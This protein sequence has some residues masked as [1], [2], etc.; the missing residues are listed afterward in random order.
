M[1][2]LF[3]GL[4]VYSQG[5]NIQ[6]LIA[7]EPFIR[8][9]QE[10][11]QQEDFAAVE[12][13]LFDRQDIAEAKKM[14]KKAVNPEL[15]KR[16][17]KINREIIQVEDNYEEFKADFSREIRAGWDGLMA[18][19]EENG[20]Q[21]ADLQ[22]VFASYN[23]RKRDLLSVRM[24]AE[25]RFFT[26]TGKEVVL[27]LEGRQLAG[28]WRLNQFR[29]EIETPTEEEAYEELEEAVETIEEEK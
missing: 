29:P 25:L 4:L 10:A 16:A 13:L 15:V 1:T 6:P 27:H 5:Q 18:Y 14:L 20:F 21:W 11:V 26:E 22:Y 19:D 23:I 17:E 7:P 12:A 28:R 9:F 24:E 3:L 2:C 8:A